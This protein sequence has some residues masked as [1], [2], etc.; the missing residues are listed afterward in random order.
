MRSLLVRIMLATLATVL[1]SVFIFG[2]SLAAVV[3]PI[4]ERLIHHFQSRQI[5]DARDAL[6]RG[7]PAAAGAYLE[8]SARGLG[9]T[10]YLTDSRGVDVVTGENRAALL[11]GPRPRFGPPR[12][13]DK[14]VVVEPSDDRQYNLIIVATPPLDAWSI[15][16]A[17]RLRRLSRSSW[18]MPTKSSTTR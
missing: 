10:H 3:G 16:L 5:E 12:I 13:G 11:N 2:A 1:V 4:N 17:P 15:F 14:I 9:G 8:R 7:G 6:A 18:R